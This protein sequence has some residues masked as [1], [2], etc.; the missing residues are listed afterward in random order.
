MA[1]IYILFYIQHVDVLFTLY[2]Y[3]NVFLLDIS[4]FNEKSKR[5]VDVVLGKQHFMF[6]NRTLTVMDLVI[7]GLW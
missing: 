1:I 2:N 6:L 3:L 7:T 5:R 4:E